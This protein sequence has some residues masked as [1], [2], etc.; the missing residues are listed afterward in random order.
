[1]RTMKHWAFAAIAASALALAGCGGGGSSSQT[2]VASPGGGG[3]T[4][5]PTPMMCPEG[6]VG[7]YPDC[8]DPP[9]ADLTTNFAAAQDLNGDAL[10]AG[11]L[12]SDAEKSA[13]LRTT[14]S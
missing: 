5:D 2:S 3:G 13:M 14:T 10:A 6:Q 11:E 4:T 1:M 7:T 9:P 12:A 8:M